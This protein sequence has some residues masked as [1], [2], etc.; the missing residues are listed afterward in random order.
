MYLTFQIHTANLAA[1]RNTSK[2]K[3]PGVQAVGT[4]EWQTT[5]HC[6]VVGGERKGS[7]RK[8]R[9]KLMACEKVRVNSADCA[10][11]KRVCGIVPRGTGGEGRVGGNAGGALRGWITESL[12]S[13][14]R[15]LDL[16]LNGNK[17]SLL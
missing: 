14:V 8:A 3:V 11:A 1:K 2:E 7:Q 12:G 13:W 15:T 10:G 4:P 9:P 5:V 6:S 17:E 16:I